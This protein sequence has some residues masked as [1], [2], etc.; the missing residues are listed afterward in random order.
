MSSLCQYCEKNNTKSTFITCSK[1]TMASERKAIKH[2]FQIGP[3]TNAIEA[4][5]K[6]PKTLPI[7]LK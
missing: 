2:F 6:V 1:S 5:L 7:T 3:R 4:T